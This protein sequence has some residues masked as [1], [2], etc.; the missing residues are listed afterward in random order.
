VQRTKQAKGIFM[1]VP[2]IGTIGFEAANC[3][4]RRKRLKNNENNRYRLPLPLLLLRRTAA[5]KVGGL[6]NATF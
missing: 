5:S 2:T 3:E 1:Q 4:N 6:S